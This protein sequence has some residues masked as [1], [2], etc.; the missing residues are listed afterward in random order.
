MPLGSL[1][2]MASGPIVAPVAAH[3]CRDWAN[4]DHL[5]CR[6]HRLVDSTPGEDLRY[7]KRAL[8]VQD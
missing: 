7:D 8:P 2:V 5:A 3:R 1:N 6:H 4:H